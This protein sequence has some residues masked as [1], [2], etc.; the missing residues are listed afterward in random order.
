MNRKK[1][2]ISII[3]GLVLFMV[4]SACGSSQEEL[5]ATTTQ[6]AADQ[7]STQTAEAPTATQTPT[8]T[9]TPTITNTPK[10]TNTP[11]ATP[12][13][14]PTATPTFTLMTID[15]IPMALY[16]STQYPFTIPYPAELVE[17]HLTSQDKELLT[18]VYANSDET[19]MFAIAEEDLVA[20]GA[21]ETSLDEYVDLVVFGIETQGLTIESQQD[22]VN[23]QGLPAKILVATDPSGIFKVSRLI[24]V[25]EN[26]IG[27]S[28]SYIFLR[29]TH[30]EMK[31]VIDFSFNNFQVM[32]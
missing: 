30:Q 25:H 6:V 27:I 3:G 19:S 28:A 24:Y 20:L 22:V 17:Q 8:N 18:A 16:E 1:T 5:D 12:T 26:R 32:K 31:P 23:A 10:P 15:S 2:L 4:L 29:E 9:A 7:F 21:G 14:L 11:S 13:P